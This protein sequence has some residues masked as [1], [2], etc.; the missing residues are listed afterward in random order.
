MPWDTSAIPRYR[1]AYGWGARLTIPEHLR[2]EQGRIL[3]RWGE[4]VW[5]EL[6]RRGKAD[7][8]F[9]DDLVLAAEE[10]IRTRWRMEHR[11]QAVCCTPSIRHPRL[12]QDFA[13]RLAAKL[14]LSFFAAVEKIRETPAQKG[15]ENRFHQCRNLDGAFRVVE[16]SF[17]RGAVLLVDDVSDSGWTLALVSALLRQAGATAVYPFAL[18]SSTA[19]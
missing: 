6:V 18:S 19:S 13:E 9:S 4:P 2:A 3:S 8:Y 16:G 17:P 10:L 14:G 12:V 1:E 11:L 5:G 7:G 15:M